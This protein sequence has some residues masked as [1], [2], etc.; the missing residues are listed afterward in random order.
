MP[1]YNFRNKKTGV[2]WDEMMSYAERTLFLEE[3]P[4]ITQLPPSRV[5]IVRGTSVNRSLRVDNGMQEN[6]Q[7]IAEAHPNSEIANQHG[8]KSAKAV[9]T[10][11]AVEKWRKKR[12]ADAS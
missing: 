1:T 8:D 2:E 11:Q 6:L 10:R 7:R 12:A 9:K 3:H 5:N 4:H